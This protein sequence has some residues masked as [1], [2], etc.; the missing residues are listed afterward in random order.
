MV[1][2]KKKINKFGC[3]IYEKLIIDTIDALN[4]SGLAEL[5]YNYINLDDCWQSSRH[6]NGTIK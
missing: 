2:N 3:N 4:S 5:G 1:M 6:P